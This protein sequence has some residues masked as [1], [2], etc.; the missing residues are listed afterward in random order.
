MPQEPGSSDHVEA[1][2][3]PTP[4]SPTEEKHASPELPTQSTG[5]ANAPPSAARWEAKQ[6]QAEEQRQAQ[7]ETSRRSM[8]ATRPAPAAVH[9]AAPQAPSETV[10]AGAAPPTVTATGGLA[11]PAPMLGVKSSWKASTPVKQI[12]L[13]SALA[14]VSSTS[15]GPFVLAIDKAGALFLS[16]DQGDTWERVHKQWKGRAVE[17]TQENAANA[18]L[19][20]APAAQT[21]TAPGASA[22]SNSSSAS[23]PSV[24]FELLNDKGQAW[25]STDGRTWTS[26]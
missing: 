13:P 15:T 12:H 3:E 19:P 24:I 14:V 20:P 22:P 18:G 17:V 8:F 6:K 11:R 23:S 7:V 26:K 2:R 5:S 1:M 16:E 9:G 10:T 21:E 4:P 25:L